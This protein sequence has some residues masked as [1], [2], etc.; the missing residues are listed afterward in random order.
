M[1]FQA[2][3]PAYPR[4]SGFVKNGSTTSILILLHGGPGASESTLFRQFNVALEEHFLLVCWE[5]R[6]TQYYLLPDLFKNI[7]IH[8]LTTMFNARQ[9]GDEGAC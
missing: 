2:A 6:S 3:S 1:S 5:Q 8:E 9:T 4:V 7:V